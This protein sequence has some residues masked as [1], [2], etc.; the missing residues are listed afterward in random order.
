MKTV[1]FLITLIPVGIYI[2]QGLKTDGFFYENKLE[3]LREKIFNKRLVKVK[4]W[5]LSCKTENQFKNIKQYFKRYMDTEENYNLIDC[6]AANAL[7]E[8]IKQKE[9]LFLINKN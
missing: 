4:D 2:Y 9:Q 6:D 7:R 3:P 5:L 1:L 8:L